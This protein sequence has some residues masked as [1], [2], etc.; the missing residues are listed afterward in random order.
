[1]VAIVTKFMGSYILRDIDQL[2]VKKLR[3]CK[4]LEYAQNEL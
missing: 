4:D 1:M 2:L 3:T